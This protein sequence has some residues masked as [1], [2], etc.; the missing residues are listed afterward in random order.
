MT[1][2][3]RWP[4]KTKATSVYIQRKEETDFP[5][6]PVVKDSVLLVR[7]PGVPSLIGG[8]IPYAPSGSS[9]ATTKGP[10]CC[11]KD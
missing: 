5:D 4:Q 1:L 9:H 11:K 3:T 8:W 2:T 6:D 10:M 7:G